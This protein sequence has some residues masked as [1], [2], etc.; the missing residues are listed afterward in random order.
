MAIGPLK[1]RPSY[2]KN[3]ISLIA[4]RAS[5]ILIPFW[6]L[7][8]L[9]F[10]FALLWKF[11]WNF[12][13]IKFSIPFLHLKLPPSKATCNQLEYTYL[14]YTYYLEFC[15]FDFDDY[16]LE[17][18]INHLCKIIR[19]QDITCKRLWYFNS[20][21]PLL[22]VTLIS[23]YINIIFSILTLYYKRELPKTTW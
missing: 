23:H 21:M 6:I 13:D 5:N 19:D 11:S 10:Y 4:S 14:P 2:G 18:L 9:P 22:I 1:G 20:Y 15:M 16:L 17:I 3:A 7:S 12:S 8:S